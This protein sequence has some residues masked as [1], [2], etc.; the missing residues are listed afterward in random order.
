MS[1]LKALVESQPFVLALLT[2]AASVGAVYGFNV[3]VATIMAF[4]TP[5]MV[6]IGATGWTQG[7]QIEQDTQVKLHL[8]ANGTAPEHVNAVLKAMKESKAAPLAVAK[9]AAPGFI[10]LEGAIA[11]SLAGMIAAVVVGATGATAVEGCATTKN[12]GTCELAAIEQTV[13]ADGGTIVSDILS[14]VLS[15]GSTLPTLITTLIAEFGPGTVQCATEFVDSLISTYLSAGGGSGSNVVTPPPPNAGVPL[16][17]AVVI[18]NPAQAQ[19]GLAA[20]HAE[21]TKRGWPVQP[22]VASKAGGAK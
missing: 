20:L 7:K 21:M 1:K 22:A 11:L 17:I 3:P 5:I 14:A 13:T 6:A 4:I 9:P 15:G 16:P 8:L 18:A 19:A 2:L 10:K 12:A